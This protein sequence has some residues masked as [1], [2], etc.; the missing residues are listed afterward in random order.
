MLAAVI[1]FALRPGFDSIDDSVPVANGADNAAQAGDA[2]GTVAG[3]GAMICRLDP[4]LS[5]VTVSETEDV[6]FRWSAQG[7]LNGQTQFA[8]EQGR[9]SRL[10]VPANEP[11]ISLRIYEPAIG[12]YRTDK[13]LVDAETAD[14]ARALRERIKWAGC[15]ADPARLEE[16]SRM[17]ADIKALLPA[18][19]NERLVYRCASAAGD[20]PEG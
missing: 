10:L 17:Q 9:W 4:A 19:P 3:T 18:L 1:V 7:C 12:R 13:Y 8:G 11:S 20:D 14:R 15:T 5:R 16:L 2:D 6:P